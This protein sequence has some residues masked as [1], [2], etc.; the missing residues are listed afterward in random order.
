MFIDQE[1]AF[2]AL[3]F[4]PR[5]KQT[6]GSKFKLNC[7]CMICGDSLTSEYKA[8]FW[9]YELKGQINVKCFN[10]D[11]SNSLSK[12]LKEVDPDLYREYLLEKRKE[13]ASSKKESIKS[14]PKGSSFKPTNVPEMVYKPFVVEE[15][16][17]SDEDVLYSVKKDLAKFCVSVASLPE[18]HPI[19]KYCLNRNIPKNKFRYLL[20]TKDWQNLV[21]SVTELTYVNPRPECRLVIPII[22]ANKKIESFQGRALDKDNPRKYMTIKSHDDATKIYGCNTVDESKTVWVLEGPLDSLFLD[23]A[24]AITGGSLDLNILP[25]KSKRVFALDNEPRHIDTCKRLK[26]LIDAGEKVV[27]WNNWTVPGKD[28][29]DYIKNG[30]SPSDIV[31]YMSK[32]TYSGLMAKHMFN[33]YCKISLG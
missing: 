12:F 30:A 29:N 28:I 31:K 16:Q 10:C 1:F 21:N 5:F 4:R 18:K 11:Y 9:C 24:I 2:R 33:N 26:K 19:V 27:M 17:E 8:R 6:P 13:S 22:S 25:Y 7:R 32:H 14:V 23:N 20:F 15:I 3:C